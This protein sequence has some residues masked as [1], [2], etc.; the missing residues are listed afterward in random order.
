MRCMQ[1]M[2]VKMTKVSS[3][4]SCDHLSVSCSSLGRKFHS[5][6]PSTENARGPQ[7]FRRYDELMTSGELIAIQGHNNN[8][9]NNTL[10]Y[11][12]PA[13]RMTSEAHHPR[14]SILVPIES[15]YASSYESIIVTL[16]VSSTVFEILTHLA[17]K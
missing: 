14:S 11:I 4:V 3:V 13:C 1:S 2:C 7:E 10:I 6:R 9:N 16:D 12:A 15:A 8:N 5:L 17:L